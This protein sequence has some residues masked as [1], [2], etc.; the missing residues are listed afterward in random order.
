[1]RTVNVTSE[2]YF[3]ILSWK[4]PLPG[5]AKL[6]VDGARCCTNGCIAAGGVL[7]DYNE[8]WICSFQANLDYAILDNLILHGNIE[9]H[10]LGA[11]I[12]SCRHMLSLFDSVNLMHIFRECNG[13]ADALAKSG[14]D[15]D[16]G[17]VVFDSPPPQAATAF[18]DDLCEVSRSKSYVRLVI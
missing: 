16:H 10:P 5:T 11:I 17:V 13:T 2:Y 9:S 1:M 15:H 12:K 3:N 7:R 18:L 6:N 14:L 8:D 4:K